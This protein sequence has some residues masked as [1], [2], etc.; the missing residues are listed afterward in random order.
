VIVISVIFIFL[1]NWRATLIP[2]VT[3]PVAIIGTLA[4]IWLAGF[5]VN[6]LTL[7][8][9]VLATGLVVDDAIV[10]LE[11]IERRRRQGLGPRAAAVL[12][13]RQVFFAVV[14][15]TAVLASVFIPISFFPGTAGRLISEFGI[16]L[17]IALVRS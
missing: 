16:V 14:A 9:L 1:R 11:N 8:A 6:I 17:A 10:V 3:V 4:G 12:G 7:L 5:S 15:T 2:A 13:T